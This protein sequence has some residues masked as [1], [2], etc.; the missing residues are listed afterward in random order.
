MTEF[1]INTNNNVPHRNLFIIG[2]GFD[3][4]LNLKSRFSDYIK[5]P[6][7]GKEY[8]HVF[9]FISIFNKYTK[10]LK[11][12]L[13]LARLY[14]YPQNKFI[15]FYIKSQPLMNDSLDLDHPTSLKQFSNYFNIQALIW[16][17]H[18]KYR[19]SKNNSKKSYQK[20]NKEIN[21]KSFRMFKKLSYLAHQLKGI[22]FWDL[23]IIFQSIY[24]KKYL[25]YLRKLLKSIFGVSKHSQRLINKIINNIDSLKYR[26]LLYKIL[27]S[28]NTSFI[29][30]KDLSIILHKLDN[31]HYYTFNEWSDIEDTIKYFTTSIIDVPKFYKGSFHFNRLDHYFN[32]TSLFYR[33]CFKSYAYINKYLRIFNYIY[34]KLDIINLDKTLYSNDLFER[35]RNNDDDLPYKYLKKKRIK[36][37]SFLYIN[38]PYTDNPDPCYSAPLIFILLS[39]FFESF[40]RSKD[41]VLSPAFLN[42]QLKYFEQSF[43]KYLKAIIPYIY[44]HNYIDKSYKLLNKLSCDLFENGL[45]HSNKIEVLDFNYTPLS[46]KIYS[47]EHIHGSLD[48]NDIIIGTDD[49][50]IN[51]LLSN[52]ENSNI[53]RVINDNIIYNNETTRNGNRI[54]KTTTRNI[55]QLYNYRNSRYSE[56]LHFTKTYRILKMPNK[57][58]NYSFNDSSLSNIDNIVFFGHSLDVNDYPYFEAIFDRLHLYNSNVKL[59]FCYNKHSFK[60]KSS[61]KRKDSQIP[62]II[63]LLR[64]YGRTMNNKAH[65]NNLISKMLIENRIRFFD[66]TKSVNSVCPLKK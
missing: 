62:A 66:A 65:G 64:M 60:D 31:S 15:K 25:I 59:I 42:K 36:D 33:N 40:S 43:S 47:Q 48:N 1:D 13:Q 12:I 38:I 39:N 45:S 57:D 58:K 56:L 21:S 26:K 4:S 30:L 52:V 23:L 51:N 34:K 6:E 28:H 5:D 54:N 7:R 49:T 9:N 20:M 22:N 11:N 63:N 44:K 3:L 27:D 14:Q 41:G 29:Q 32:N 55:K 16:H 46:T 10:H 53:R 18:I 2:N 35:I 50:E 17:N 19:F 61:E 24:S 37:I 8:E